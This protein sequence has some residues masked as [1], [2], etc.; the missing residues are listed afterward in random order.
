LY[1]AEEHEYEEGFG[2]SVNVRIGN[3]E[4]TW[5]RS[6]NK[7]NPFEKIKTVP[8]MENGNDFKVVWD[9]AH[10]NSFYVTERMYYYLD[11]EKHRDKFR[12]LRAKLYITRLLQRAGQSF[13]LQF[14]IERAQEE[15]L[16]P[17]RVR[18]SLRPVARHGQVGVG[19]GSAGVGVGSHSQQYQQQQQ[20]QQ[21]QQ[22]SNIIVS[23]LGGLG[24]GHRS[25]SG[26]ASSN[27]PDVP[28]PRTNAMLSAFSKTHL[29]TT[30]ITNQQ[31]PSSS[32]SSSTP[33]FG[34]SFASSSGSSSSQQQQQQQQ[35]SQ[36]G[37]ALIDHFSAHPFDSSRIQSFPPMFAAPRF[38]PT[39]VAAPST[40]Q[41]SL[42]L[43]GTGGHHHHHTI[44]GTGA[45]SSSSQ[46]HVSPSGLLRPLAVPA[47]EAS[48]LAQLQYAQQAQ[49]QQMFAQQALEFHQ[50]RE[51]LLRQQYQQDAAAR[52]YAPLSHYASSS[53]KS[54]YAPLHNHVK[55]RS[56]GDQEAPSQWRSESGSM[57][58]SH[59][60]TS[61]DLPETATKRRST[62]MVED[63]VRH[64][65]A[66][67]ILNLA[68]LSAEVVARSSTPSSSSSTTTTPSSASTS[69]YDRMT[70]DPSS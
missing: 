67:G 37:A 62:E 9:R 66:P 65:F 7:W 14:I 12:S 48:K 55:S 42:G 26:G 23:G 25:S 27:S 46:H 39:M 56:L 54:Q 21:Q 35:Q 52:A 6:R 19:V 59:E 24:G 51:A 22:H 41:M 20:Q 49:L 60:T 16:E 70:I 64:A 38:Y 61:Y 36:I 15:E 5:K 45:T 10:S 29:N 32:S 33:V 2:P 44:S 47:E 3:D 18:E 53:F 13:L 11:R 40:P 30:P 31:A 58:R 43:V 50:Q 17:I 8:G 63:N 68:A 1:Q 28:S 4:T 69:T 57:K 34:Q